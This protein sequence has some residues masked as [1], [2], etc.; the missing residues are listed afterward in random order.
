[1]LNSCLEAVL[2]PPYILP[3][4]ATLQAEIEAQPLLFNSFM[5]RDANEKPVYT[6]APS[7]DQLK[8]VLEEKLAEY[9]ENNAVMDLVGRLLQGGCRAGGAGV[10]EQ[11]VTSGHMQY[12][13]KGIMLV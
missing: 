9:N 13:L 8:K 10:G 11:G 7:Y 5:T 3:L 12:S 2:L 6:A 4:C 1:M